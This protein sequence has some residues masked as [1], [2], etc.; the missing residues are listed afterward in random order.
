MSFKLNPNFQ[1]RL[2]FRF[3]ALAGF[4]A[5]AFL[6]GARLA[7]S[8]RF[9]TFLALTFFL[10]FFALRAMSQFPLMRAR[11]ILRLPQIEPALSHQ[12]QWA[13]TD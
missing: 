4:F 11:L 10:D 5:F 3:F 6:A 2:L 7:F 13:L 12:R 1:D 9:A 8:L